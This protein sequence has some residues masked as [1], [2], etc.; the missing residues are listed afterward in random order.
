MAK[1][2]ACPLPMPYAAPYAILYYFYEKTRY[3]AVYSA[4]DF[5]DLD[6]EIGR[7]LRFGGIY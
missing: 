1:Y 4:S 5:R 3:L 2:Y 7:H 6:V